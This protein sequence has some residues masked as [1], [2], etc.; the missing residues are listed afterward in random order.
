MHKTGTCHSISLH[1]NTHTVEPNAD[2]IG[3]NHLSPAHLHT[4]TANQ[5]S[6]SRP[7][8][9]LSMLPPCP[10]DWTLSIERGST[11]RRRPCS[12]V[13]PGGIYFTVTAPTT[14]DSDA[15]PSISV[16]GTPHHT[17]HA[18]TTRLPSLLSVIKYR[19]EPKWL[20]ASTSTWMCA[21]VEQNSKKESVPEIN[22]Y[23]LLSIRGR[24]SVGGCWRFIR[25]IN[26]KRLLPSFFE[27]TYL[28]KIWDM[29]LVSLC[30]WA[31]KSTPIELRKSRNVTTKVN[32]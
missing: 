25:Y 8:V 21:P 11:R 10:T 3:G 14:I 18:L 29:M 26:N 20:C 13:R 17:T 1:S 16:G 28:H 4:H 9:C 24:V 22:S 31:H 32:P 23:A 12:E 19:R 27:R 30:L 7:S 15:N 6:R 5:A 2:L